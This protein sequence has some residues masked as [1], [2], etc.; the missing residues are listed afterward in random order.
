MIRTDIVISTVIGVLLTGG[1]ARA[2]ELN[3]EQIV[4]PYVCV[5]LLLQDSRILTNRE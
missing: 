2:Q 4:K 3:I 1:S 5:M